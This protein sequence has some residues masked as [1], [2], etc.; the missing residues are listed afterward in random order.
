M[1]I[2]QSHTIGFLGGNRNAVLPVVS[3]K[4][5]G[6]YYLIIGTHSAYLY[7]QKEARGRTEPIQKARKGAQYKLQNNYHSFHNESAHGF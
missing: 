7:L 5:Y 2:F 1:S 3:K 6:T 4:V